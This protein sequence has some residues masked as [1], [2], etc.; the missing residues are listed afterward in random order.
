MGLLSKANLL[1]TKERLAFSTFI[2]NNNIQNVAL[3]SLNNNYYSIVN[4]FCFDINSI[5]NSYSTKD[6][7]DGICKEVNKTYVLSKSDNSIN[8][9][10]QL[11]S[12]E[13][14]DIIFKVSIIKNSKNDILLI[15]NSE[16]TPQIIS[17]FNNIEINFFE[18]IKDYPFNQ[19]KNYYKYQVHFDDISFIEDYTEERKNQII[20]ALNNECVNRINSFYI[21]DNLSVK[22]NQMTIK[23]IFSTLNT[24]NSDLFINHLKLNLTDVLHNNARNLYIEYSGTCNTAGELSDFLKAE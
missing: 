20:S 7:W 2:K 6:F 16:I 3:F 23:L 4:S 15:C 5:I 17:D 8:C 1:D 13:L 21:S 19:N 11:F 24:I 10:Y 12:L 14:I 22:Y 9:L 18:V